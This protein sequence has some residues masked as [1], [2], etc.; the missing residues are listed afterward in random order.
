[1][2]VLGAQ[3]VT[4]TRKSK[5]AQLN[6]FVTLENDENIFGELNV[7]YFKDLVVEESEQW[8]SF[9]SNTSCMQAICDFINC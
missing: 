3:A 7:N 2:E 8:L 5:D 9:L 6:N 4:T 1:L